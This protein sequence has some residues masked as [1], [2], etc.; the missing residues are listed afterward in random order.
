MFAEQIGNA[1]KALFHQR[2]VGLSFLS[3]FPGFITDASEWIEKIESM[4]GDVKE[5]APRIH[6]QFLG[7][8]VFRA[9]SEVSALCLHG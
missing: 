3:S 5:V 7:Q 8:V 1:R 9:S 6:E 4:T 2:I